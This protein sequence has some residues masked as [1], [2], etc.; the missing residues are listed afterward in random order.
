MSDHAP[1][2]GQRS[3]DPPDGTDPPTDVDALH[4]IALFDGLAQPVRHRVLALAR[5]RRYRRGDAIY[6][7][8][9]V[10]DELLLLMSG[11]VALFRAA[12]TGA[13]AVLTVVRPPDLLGEEALAGCVP[14]FA[15]AEA[16]QDAFA[17]ALPAEELATLVEGHA[18]LGEAARRCLV[19]RAAA[20]AEQRADDVLLDLPGRVAKALV[21]IADHNAAVTLS[22]QTLAAL[23]RGSR[24]SVN[25]VLKRFARSGWVRIQAGRIVLTDIEALGRRARVLPDGTWVPGPAPEN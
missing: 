16:L 21:A 1:V 6:T 20:F 23:A 12:A 7:A 14:R 2:P 4:G 18:P 22:Q 13:R 19:H 3:G 5:P 17:F 15:S 10:G 25:Q 11:T 9:A 8:G 24:Q